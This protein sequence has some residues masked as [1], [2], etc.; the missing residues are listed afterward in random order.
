MS[1][2][3]HCHDLAELF[4]PPNRTAAQVAFLAQHIQDAV[5]DGLEMLPCGNC[6]GEERGHDGLL[7]CECPAPLGGAK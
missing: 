7:L 5:E 3:T 2:D 4:L 6:G 1:Y